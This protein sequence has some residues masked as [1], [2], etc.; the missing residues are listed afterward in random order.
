M[1]ACRSRVSQNLGSALR[2]DDV[3]EELLWEPD[4]ATGVVAIRLRS[5]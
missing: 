3:E 2:E 4:W 5:G 1:K